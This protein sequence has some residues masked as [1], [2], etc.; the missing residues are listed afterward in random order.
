MK[1]NGRPAIFVSV[2]EGQH[3]GVDDIKLETPLVDRARGWW[4]VTDR[5]DSCELLVAV[6]AGVVVDVWEIDRR[7]GWQPM[8]VGAISTRPVTQTDVETPHGRK[9]KYCQI[10][11]TVPPERECCV[12]KKL[13]EVSNLDQMY[14]PFRYGYLQMPVI[15]N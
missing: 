15:G 12:D 3:G 9:C 4:S 1:E 13:S 8:A 11:Q 2:T 14:G 7:F 6:D 10:T 5:V